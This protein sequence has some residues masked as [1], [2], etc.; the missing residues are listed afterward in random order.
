MEKSLHAPLM[1]YYSAIRLF[2]PTIRYYFFRKPCK[3]YF[4]ILIGDREIAGFRRDGYLKVLPITRFNKVVP[5]R[6]ISPTRIN[7]FNAFGGISIDN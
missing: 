7:F 2:D 5:D 1:I 4:F 3:F 6:S